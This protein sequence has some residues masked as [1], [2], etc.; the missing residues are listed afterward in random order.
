MV[1]CLVWDGNHTSVWFVDTSGQFLQAGAGCGE[2]LRQALMG[3]GMPEVEAG[4]T[5]EHLCLRATA[6]MQIKYSRL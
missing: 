2:Q 4:A 3:Y 5:A 6:L 1:R